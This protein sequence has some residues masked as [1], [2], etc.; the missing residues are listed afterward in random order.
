MKP[1]PIQPHTE[2]LPLT[3]DVRANMTKRHA[4]QVWTIYRSF[5]KPLAEIDLKRL[6]N[7]WNEI[8]K[9]YTTGNA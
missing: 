5:R 7:C 3:M 8:V 1:T 6:A 4:E 9:Q 2:C